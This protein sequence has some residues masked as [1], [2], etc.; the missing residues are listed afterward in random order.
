MF[1]HAS[2]RN[3]FAGPGMDTRQWISYGVVTRATEDSDVLT[4]D[5]EV[6]S[7]LVTVLL[8]PSENFV[9]CRIAGSVAG[10][11][12]G[13][14]HPW[15]EGDEVIVA[16]PGGNEKGGCIILGRLNNSLD[17]W[18][19]QVAGSDST[20]NTFAFHRRRTPYIFETSET[21]M[22]RSAKTEA[23]FSLSQAGEWTL[24]NTEGYIAVANDF[25]TMQSSDSSLL[26]QLNLT[27]KLVAV[28]SGGSLLHLKSTGASQFYTKGALQIGTSG[29]SP[30]GF[31]A[32]T[33][34]AVV[35]L[36]DALL[37]A[38]GVV[39]VAPTPLTGAAIAAAKLGLVNAAL[40]SYSLSAAAYSGY[41]PAVLLNLQ[42]PPDQTGNIPNIG[43]AGLT[44]S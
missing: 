33:T 38:F 1:D 28:E 14:W 44:I 41:K 30:A 17:V 7:P 13:E 40:A 26:V 24:A 22:F 27:D 35:S 8:Q 5:P 36:I 39:F 10:N 18:P 9:A 19:V 21:M 15:V 31:H 29:S 23:Y 3:A 16:I 12:E 20:S 2:L 37:F 25:I 11:G 4:F 34:E 32:T 6:G 42:V 43:A